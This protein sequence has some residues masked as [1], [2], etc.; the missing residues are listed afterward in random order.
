MSGTCP[1]CGSVLQ[2]QGLSPRQAELLDVR[3]YSPSIKE[4]S[5]IRETVPS[6]IH[7]LIA[8]LV[9]R[10][11]VTNRPGFARSLSVL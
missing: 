11:Y 7:R 2:K 1:M 9:D 8:A 4:L 10:G 5:E 6:N 3:G